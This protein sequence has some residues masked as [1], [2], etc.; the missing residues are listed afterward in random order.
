M[1]KKFGAILLLFHFIL[2]FILTAQL[3]EKTGTSFTKMLAKAS[4]GQRVIQCG[5][6][7]KEEKICLSNEDYQA[8]LKIVEAE[9]GSEDEKGKILVANVVLNRVKSEQFPNTVK[10]V[11]LQKENGISQFSPVGNGRYEKVVI[12]DETKQAVERALEGEDFSEGAL[13]FAAR[14]Y[15]SPSRMK[16][17]DEHLTRLFSHGGHEFF[18]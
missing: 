6:L 7:E 11:V 15:A 18:V 10:E 13:Y 9:A 4:S 8:L 12:S 14:K 16:W 5:I 3:E 17:F 2:L 1:Y